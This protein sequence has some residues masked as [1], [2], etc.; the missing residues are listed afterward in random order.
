[1]PNLFE[2]MMKAASSNPEWRQKIVDARERIEEKDRREQQELERKQ[3][4]LERRREK[5][6]ADEKARMEKE[7]REKEQELM[8]RLRPFAFYYSWNGVY[9]RTVGIILADDIDDATQRIRDR[10]IQSIE[11][12]S[13]Y[14]PES[15]DDVRLQVEP[16]DLSTGMFTVYDHD[17]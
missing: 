14:S 16:I 8:A 7:R 10:L 17:D 15:I 13:E 1:M 12:D 2:A 5:R 11:N 9:S 3:A 6:L 4:E